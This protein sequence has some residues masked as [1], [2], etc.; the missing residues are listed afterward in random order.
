MFQ[1]P[2][3]IGQIRRSRGRLRGHRSRRRRCSR[4]TV[5]GFRP[6][7]RGISRRCRTPN[8]TPWLLTPILLLILI[9]IVMLMMLILM[10]LMIVLLFLSPTFLFFSLVL[11]L[12]VLLSQQLLLL[13]LLLLL[14]LKLPSN[15]W[16]IVEPVAAPTTTVR[17]RRRHYNLRL[18]KQIH[19]HNHTR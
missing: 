12:L 10:M 17:G 4:N 16:R 3:Q 13:L 8:P 14:K 9:L 2:I 6:I 1:E 7:F 5:V 19:N 15:C 11:L 18:F